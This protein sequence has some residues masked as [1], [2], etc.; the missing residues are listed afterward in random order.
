VSGYDSDAL[1]GF[2]EFFAQIL[3]GLSPARRKT[4][5][6]KLGQALRRS[7]L[8]RIAANVQPD[9]APMEPR[10]PRQDRRGR[11]RRRAGGKMFRELRRAKLWRID[12]RP[13]SVEVLP[14]TGANVAEIHHFGLPGTVGRDREGRAIKYR[15]PERRLLG[16]SKEDEKLAL[17]V[18][19]EFLG[20]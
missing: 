5:A 18:A 10:K 13:D 17:D 4:L 16:F 19:A 14:K 11:L 20:D 2:D 1:A 15:Y 9:G 7:N 8:R 6:R 12:A 3:A